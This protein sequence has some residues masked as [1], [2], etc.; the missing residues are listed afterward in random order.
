[1]SRRR[2]TRFSRDWSSDVCS[3]DLDPQIITVNDVTGPTFN[4]ALPADITISCEDVIPAAEELTAIDCTNPINQNIQNLT[5]DFYLDMNKIISSYDSNNDG[6]GTMFSDVLVTDILEDDVSQDVIDYFNGVTVS[7]TADAVSGALNPR[8]RQNYQGFALYN[9]K[10]TLTLSEPITFQISGNPTL[11]S[12]EKLTFSGDGNQ[13]YPFPGSPGV[14]FFGDQ[15]I[16][17]TLTTPYIVY[18]SGD[19]TVQNSAQVFGGRG[20]SLIAQQED[21]T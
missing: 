16:V 2:H 4:E 9:G 15:N 12:G 18:N 7:L 11:T 20:T 3:S 14:N 1:S 21:P 17:T 19:V 6:F 8:V 5:S 13:L 10:M